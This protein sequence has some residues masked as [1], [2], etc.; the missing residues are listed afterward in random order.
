MYET[1]KQRL[2]GR[3]VGDIDIKDSYHFDT[4]KKYVGNFMKEAAQDATETAFIQVLR[5]LSKS[6]LWPSRFRGMDVVDALDF[7]LE[8]QDSLHKIKKKKDRFSMIQK[9][10][11]LGAG[12]IIEDYVFINRPFINKLLTGNS[13]KREMDNFKQLYARIEDAKFSFY[14]DQSPIL[15]EHKY[16]LEKFTR[17]R[18]PPQVTSDGEQH[19][20]NNTRPHPSP[21]KLLYITLENGV[22]VL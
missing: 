4:A 19:W 10:S 13:N 3:D 18:F 16:V 5:H 20:K 2:H 15:F 12:A 7:C 8:V 17:V 14:M 11:V 6:D 21:D 1:K 9:F 22:R